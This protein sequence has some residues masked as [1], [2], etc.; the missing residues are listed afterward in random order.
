MDLIAGP[1]GSGKS[2]F[3]PVAE[4]DFDSFNIDDRRKELN[5]GSSH[6]I[7]DEVRQQAIAD[8]EAFIAEH[9]RT[10]KSLS[11]EVTRAK[12]ITFDQ[13]ADARQRHFRIHLTYIAAE[14][15][16]CLQRVANR[17]DMGGHGNSPV[18]L[19]KTYAAS[20]AN[21]P[22]AIRE[23]DFVQVYDNSVHADR[24]RLMLETQRGAPT[25]VAPDRPRWL[26]TALAGTAY[27]A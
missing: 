13:A 18:E 11:I 20:M 22:R 16:D 17:V 12:E 10:G 23:F 15:E 26:K 8:Y 24:P 14:P 25:Y 19:R 9:I 27:A 3:F 5:H 1:Q 4:R 21:L 2:R 6:E 7:P